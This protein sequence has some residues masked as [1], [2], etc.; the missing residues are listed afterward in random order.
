MTTDDFF[1]KMEDHATAE[2]IR[3]RKPTQGKPRVIGTARG[4]VIVILLAA[5]IAYHS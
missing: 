4:M 1:K 5:K 3:L 2:G